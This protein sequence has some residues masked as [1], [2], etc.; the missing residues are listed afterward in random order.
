MNK[1]DVYVKCPFYRVSKNY[2]IVCEGIVDETNLHLQFRND[3]AR[4]E[5]KS[6]NCDDQYTMCPLSQMISRFK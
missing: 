1:E 6:W 2:Q 3:K 5:W 4:K